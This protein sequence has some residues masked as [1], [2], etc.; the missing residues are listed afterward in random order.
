MY[1]VCK[2]KY[3]KSKHEKCKSGKEEKI[4][5]INAIFIKK[6]EI[7]EKLLSWCEKIFSCKKK[8][9]RILKK[10]PLFIHV[11]TKRAEKS[12]AFLMLSWRIYRI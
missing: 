4:M 6:N 5:Q 11:N 8:L 9:R 2:L 10:N 12:Q 1:F 7:K 3:V